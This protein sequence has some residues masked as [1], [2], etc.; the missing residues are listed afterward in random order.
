MPILVGLGE[1]AARRIERG[2][3]QGVL[4]LDADGVA[5]LSWDRRAVRWCAAG[6]IHAEAEGH[7]VSHACEWFIAQIGR[8]I[9]DFND[10][11]GRTV[12]EVA[13]LLRTLPPEEFP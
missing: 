8:D 10:A 12:A 5:V 13:A 7:V 6:A 3:C 11:A 2:W 4:A 1:R 9:T